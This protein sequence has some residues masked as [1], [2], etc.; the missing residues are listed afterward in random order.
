MDFPGQIRSVAQSCLT[1][2]D[3][4][5]RSKPGLPGSRTGNN[6]KILRVLVKKKKIQ[7]HIN[8]IKEKN[9][10][11]DRKMFLLFLN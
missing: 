4:M 3:P 6:N 8:I 11:N 9:K 5:N 2:F 1:L 10:T 7:S